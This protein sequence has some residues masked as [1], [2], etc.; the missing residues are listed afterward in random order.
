VK[1]DDTSQRGIHDDKFGDSI[2]QLLRGSLDE[3]KQSIDKLADFFGFG[4]GGGSGV[5]GPGGVGGGKPAG[6]LDPAREAAAMDFFQKKGPH[7]RPGRRIRWDA[8][9]GVSP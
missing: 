9:T 2:P 3:L 7:S 8:R 6:P 5:G 1:R 4:K